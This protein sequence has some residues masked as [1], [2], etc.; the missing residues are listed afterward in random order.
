MAIT[1]AAVGTVAVGG[2]L[3]VLAVADLRTHRLPD[4]LTLPGAALILAAAACA[5]ALIPAVLG[6][7]ALT[8]LYGLG[9]LI[10]PAGLGA[11]D[12]KL[13]VGLGAL[14]GP[15][16]VPAWF[17]AAVTA[18]LLTAGCGLVRRRQRVPHGPAMCLASAAAVALAWAGR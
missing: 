4:A 7:V 1:A 13:A 15:F 10:A 6:A 2:W 14:T 17:L 3:I 5:G 12:V 8:G 11:G 16:G 9:H 18:P